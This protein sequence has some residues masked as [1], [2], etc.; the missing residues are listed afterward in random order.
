[1]AVIDIMIEFYSEKTSSS[2]NYFYR[3]LLELQERKA[4]IDAEA[5]KL[6]LELEIQESQRE[7]E[8]LQ[9]LKADFYHRGTM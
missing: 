8:R 7:L 1:M 4:F 9:H 6:R 5:K 2:I 3:E